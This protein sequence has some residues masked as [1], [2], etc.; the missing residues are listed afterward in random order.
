MKENIQLFGKNFESQIS[1]CKKEEDSVRALEEQYKKSLEKLQ[2]NN[3]KR[4]KVINQIRLDKVNEINEEL[5]NCEEELIKLLLERQE[6][7]AAYCKKHGHNDVLIKSVFLGYTGSHSFKYGRETNRRNEY[8]CTVCGRKD[9]FR[10]S[11]YVQ[12]QIKKY[13]QVIPDDI[14][15]DTTLNKN[16]KS[17]KAIEEEIQKLKEYIDYLESLKASLCNLFGHDAEPYMNETFVCKCCNR[18]LSYRE[19]IDT[20]HAAKYR[21]IVP[22]YYDTYPEEDYIISSR[23]HLSSSLPSYKTYQRRRKRTK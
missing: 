20:Y 5:K 10:G 23:S 2:D 3:E 11:T 19:Y 16:G 15:E 14:Y 12:S 17:L 7:L 21:G 8:R 13:V 4:R 1:E 18:T 6:I 22:Y 9:V